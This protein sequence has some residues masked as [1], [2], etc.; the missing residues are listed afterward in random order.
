MFSSLEYVPTVSFK[1]DGDGLFHIIY[2][3]SLLLKFYYQSNFYNFSKVKHKILTRIQK[4]DLNVSVQ[5][6]YFAGWS[7]HTTTS[8]E[9]N[10]IGSTDTAPNWKVISK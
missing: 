3:P 10:P 4:S 5:L 9:D 6:T 1:D 8:A 7:V 2:R